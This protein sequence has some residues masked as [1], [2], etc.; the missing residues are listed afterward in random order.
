M[1]NPHRGETEV[2]GIGV[3]RFDWDAIARLVDEF[4]AGFDSVISQAIVEADVEVLAKTVAIGAVDAITPEF[5]ADVSPP[6]TPTANAIMKA[7]NLA[8]HG[9]EG[10]PAAERDENPPPWTLLVRGVKRLLRRG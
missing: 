9:T 5:V 1:L 2:P 3:I 8:F 7:L 4:G 6:I 10:A